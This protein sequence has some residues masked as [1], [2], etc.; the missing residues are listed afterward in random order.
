MECACKVFAKGGFLH[1]EGY[2][3]N[4][5]HIMEV[6]YA[7]L[8]ILAVALDNMAYRYPYYIYVITA[9]INGCRPLRLIVLVPGLKLVIGTVIMGVFPLCS[10]AFI[11]A[12]VSFIFAVA[13]MGLFM[14]K[15]FS[16]TDLSVSREIN[17]IGTYWDAFGEERERFWQAAP[18]NYDNIFQAWFSTSEVFTANGWE[19]IAKS[20]ISATG[21]GTGPSLYNNPEYA[22]YFYVALI[23]GA[24][25]LLN[26][27]TG[28]V[29]DTFNTL[30]DS[31]NGLVLMT[32]EQLQW[33]EAQRSILLT[34]PKLKIR[35]AV[36]APVRYLQVLA[37]SPGLEWTIT[38]CIL[39]NVLLM[40]TSHYGEPLWQAVLLWYLNIYF[41]MVYLSEFCIKI[42]AFGISG[43]WRDP[44]NRFDFLVL[45][46]SLF[47]IPFDV[48]A[49]PFFRAL[50]LVRVLR[51]FKFARGVITLMQTLMVSS[52]SIINVVAVLSVLFF[53][54]TI[55]GIA[56]FRDVKHQVMINERVNFEHSFSAF[57]ALAQVATFD[58]WVTM[59][60]EC[61]VQPPYCAE[62]L[63][64]CGHPILAPIYFYLAAILFGLILSSFTVGIMLSN[65]MD[66]RVQIY[67]A[68]GSDILEAFRNAWAEHDPLGIGQIHSGLLEPML[69]QLGEP[70]GM[71]PDWKHGR[72][73]RF[74]FDLDLRVDALGYVKF[75]STFH[76]LLRKMNEVERTNN[77][78]DVELAI[79]ALVA[80]SDHQYVSKIEGDVADHDQHWIAK[81]TSE[82][83]YW[84]TSQLIAARR[85]QRTFRRYRQNREEEEKTREA[86]VHA[87]QRIRRHVSDLT[88]EEDVPT[89]IKEKKVTPKVRFWDIVHDVVSQQRQNPD[90]FAELQD[91][92][93]EDISSSDE[94][95]ISSRRT[96]IPEWTNSSRSLP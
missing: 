52:V 68:L 60:R 74:L 26:L 78:D 86:Q 35:L 55:G 40:L 46:I 24:F 82:S 44:W 96:P 9:I 51:L 20:A 88:G 45:C 23:C 94:G 80:D 32:E 28:V 38:F 8:S 61:Q 30:K 5:W 92:L 3:R 25:F 1:G 4:P 63:H 6:G 70:L 57:A 66:L 93:D 83:V 54:F 56:L 72:K 47:A 49:G 65:F 62:D 2:F 76:A 31:T 7:A 37:H 79:N 90:S 14:G 10:A 71:N 27:F 91:N 21:I 53:A 22:L 29:V 16:C 42:I 50:R 64:N 67:G 34:S 58:H 48:I 89:Q 13:G 18:S 73:E 12:V 95:S 11:C 59:M 87:L 84:S 41:C 36:F 69:I 43:Y 33:V 81:K 17:C 15:F 19:V 75:Y 77:L 39:A 85:L